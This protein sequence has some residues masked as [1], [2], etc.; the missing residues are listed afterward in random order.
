MSLAAKRAARSEIDLLLSLARVNVTDSAIEHCRRLLQEHRDSFDWG[1]FLDQAGRHKVL[2]LVGRH[3]MRHRLHHGAD[4]IPLVPYRSVYAWAY[5][6]NKRRN[7]VLA[8]EFGRCMERLRDAGVRFA[9]R[10]GPVL[11][12]QLYGDPGLRSMADLDVLVERKDTERIGEV[13]QECGFVQGRPSSDGT[14]IEPFERSTQVFW[15]MHVNNEL[16]YVKLGD[17]EDVE[18]FAVDLCL[19]LFQQRSDGALPVAEVLDRR[20]PMKLCGTDSFGLAPE[21]QF[22]DLCLHFHKEASSRSYIEAGVDLQLLKFLDL[23]LACVALSE[24]GHW[25]SFIEQAR[26]AGAIESVYYTL[27]HVSLVYPDMVPGDR[28][29]ALRPDNRHFLDEYGQVDG[30]IGTW[31]VPFADRL[32][33]R[34]RRAMVQGASSVPRAI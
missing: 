25:V 28:L 30:H 22:L 11:G 34:D 17:G 15:R 33:S 1:F 6:G 18:H 27:F 16:P 4:E 26:Q 3:V 19:D 9:V 5:L 14:A 13:L 20:V 24:S 2:P 8:R 7:S 32:F 10:K 12:E 23:A 29:E 31:Q 21:D